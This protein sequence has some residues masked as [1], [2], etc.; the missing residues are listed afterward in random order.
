MKK[1]SISIVLLSTFIL[2]GCLDPS[3]PKCDSKETK[4][5]FFKLV[6]DELKKQRSREQLISMKNVEEIAFN[7]QSEIRVCKADGI[8][9]DEDTAWFTYKIYWG[10]EKS[11]LKNKSEKMFYVEITDSDYY[12]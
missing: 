6:N 4:E 2:T 12:E 9:S 3:L 7:K 1:L 5:V 8:Y 11:I 10:K